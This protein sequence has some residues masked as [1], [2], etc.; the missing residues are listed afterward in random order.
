MG[1]FSQGI[2][3]SLSIG[4]TKTTSNQSAFKFAMD[5]L[6]PLE[7]SL[8]LVLKQV[9]LLFTKNK[10]NLRTTTLRSC[11]RI[12]NM[13]IHA[14]MRQAIRKARRSSISW[15]RMF[16]PL[17]DLGRRKEVVLPTLPVVTLATHV[18]GRLRG[19]AGYVMG[20]I[21]QRK[22]GMS[23]RGARNGS[24]SASA[25]GNY[26][27]LTGIGVDCLT[28]LGMPCAMLVQDVH[29]IFS[30]PCDALALCHSVPKLPKS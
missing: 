5:V 24:N 28:R 2:L 8:T 30:D 17:A 29:A 1:L 13:R 10:L 12:K 16:Q 4:A 11:Q 19:M 20:A 21:G 23:G 26:Q 6:S 15:R 14:P 9:G 27:P 3:R 18:R 22:N 25:G 7:Q